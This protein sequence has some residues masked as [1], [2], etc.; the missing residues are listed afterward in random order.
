MKEY[1]INLI[2]QITGISII[3]IMEILTINPNYKNMYYNYLAMIINSFNPNIKKCIE[4]DCNNIN[5][6]QKSDFCCNKCLLKFNK[7]FK[8]KINKKVLNEYK[9]NDFIENILN[10]KSLINDY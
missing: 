6:R 8:T 7:Q 1:Y 10:D 9:K 3:D 4:K 2:H 5:F